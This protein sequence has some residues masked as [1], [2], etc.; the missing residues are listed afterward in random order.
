VIDALAYEPHF[1]DH[2]APVWRRLPDRGR[3]LVPPELLERAQIAGLEPTGLRVDLRRPPAPDPRRRALVASY[4]D[5]KKG[6]R[7]GY[8]SFAFLEHGAGQSYNGVPAQ[9]GHPSYAGGLDRAD[10]ELFLVPNDHSAE[11]WRRRYPRARAAVVGSPRLFDLPARVPDGS[12]TVAI[13]FHV[14][15]TFCPEV[16]S[17]WSWY[18][19]GVAALALTHRVI[20]H[21]HPRHADAMAREYRRLGVEYVADF[22]DVCRRADVYAVD[23]SSTLFEFASTGRPVIVLN[24]PWYRRDVEHGLRF[25]SASTVGVNVDGPAELPAAI[26]RALADE[27]ELRLARS[28]ALATVYQV[29]ADAVDELVSWSRDSVAA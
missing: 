15:F 4:G 10:H 22:A 6:R 29:R 5:V 16:R 2:L 27:P 23:N 21:A 9:G 11:Q 19:D 17:S 18:R 1:L 13:S 14:S 20:G 25:W 12:T 7:L 8:G 26:E 24:A 3:F 28:R